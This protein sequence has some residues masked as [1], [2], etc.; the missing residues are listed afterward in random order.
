[1]I[2]SALLLLA[3]ALQDA[4]GAKQAPPLPPAPPL[5][6]ETGAAPVDPAIA[7]LVPGAMPAGA[8]PA[9]VEDWKRV[10]AATSVPGAALAPI[11]AFQLELE[12]VYRKNAEAGSNDLRATY[13]FFAPGFVRID[14]KDRSTMRGPRG[15]W[16]EDRKAGQKV[17]LSVGREHAEDRRQ[18]D[19]T[20]GIAKHF[21]ALTHPGSLR[22]ASL[23]KLPGPPAALPR[24]KEKDFDL[25]KRASELSW[26]RV[27]SPDFRLVGGGATAPM[28]RAT[29]GFD[30]KTG[31]VEIALLEED[32]A[33]SGLT[34]TARALRLDKSLEA[35]G[36]VVPKRIYVYS[37][38]EGKLPAAFAPIPGMEL[39]VVRANLAPALGPPDFQLP[40]D[41]A[42]R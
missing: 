31:R 30:P 10:L 4:T 5:P 20:L 9:A 42:P 14:L 41:P 6:G 35:Q 26:L 36:Y 12:V 39:F 29:L 21:V 8:A 7:A 19:E 17:E 18:L 32:R 25:E 38:E 22:L 16:L 3:L 24:A 28:T 27:R 15:D 34:A 37:V 13:K 23:E 2:R 11:S 33:A 40:Q 1:M